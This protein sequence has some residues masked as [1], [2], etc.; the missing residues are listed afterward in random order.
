MC[1]MT[2]NNENDAEKSSNDDDFSHLNDDEN[3]ISHYERELLKLFI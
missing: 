1:T 2:L 3:D